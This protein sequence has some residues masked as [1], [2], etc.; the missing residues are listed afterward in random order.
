MIKDSS[1]YNCAAQG[2]NTEKEMQINPFISRFGQMVMAAVLTS[3]DDG[4][5][6]FLFR[7]E[8]DAPSLTTST[9]THIRE[10]SF[11]SIYLEPW[12]H[13]EQKLS[14]RVE[15]IQPSDRVESSHG[16]NRS[17]VRLTRPI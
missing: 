2:R 8:V 12:F 10:P 14:S 17:S 3:K 1:H 13:L 9:R 4:L 11:F 6:Q 16:S 5:T 15:S 7:D